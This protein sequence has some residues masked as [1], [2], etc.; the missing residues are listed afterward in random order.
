MTGKRGKKAMTGGEKIDALLALAR[1]KSALDEA[2][3][4]AREAMVIALAAVDALR[5]ALENDGSEGGSLAVSN[6]MSAIESCDG[7]QRYVRRRRSDVVRKMSRLGRA[8]VSP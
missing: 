7:A 8:E 6:L 1:R 3:S 5:D 4:L 2:A